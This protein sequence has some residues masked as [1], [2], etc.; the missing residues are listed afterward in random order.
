MVRTVIDEDEILEGLVTDET[1]IGRN[2]GE[3]AAEALGAG[4]GC[5]T[6]I[7]E[8]NHSMP[9]LAVL[10]MAKIQRKG[11]SSSCCFLD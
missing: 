5:Q 3:L 11:E 2:I 9:R 1:A 4:E 10:P 8:T 6:D 7:R